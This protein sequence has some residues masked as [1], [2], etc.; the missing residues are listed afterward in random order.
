MFSIKRDTVLDPF[1]GSGT[2]I[3][4]AMQNGRNSVGYETD[5]SL[6]PL[7][8]RRTHTE[9]STHKLNI[10]KRPDQPNKNAKTQNAV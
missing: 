6:L 9:T 1:L 2:T 10:T 5:D 4:A 7:I 3:K 8:K